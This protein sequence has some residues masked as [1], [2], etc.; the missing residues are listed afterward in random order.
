MARQVLTLNEPDTGGIVD[1]TAQTILPADDA[2]FANDGNV[3]LRVLNNAGTSF[4]I[5]F[6]IPG[7]VDEAAGIVKSDNV[8]SIAAGATHFFHGFDSTTYNQEDDPDALGLEN[9]VYIDVPTSSDFR[10]TAFQV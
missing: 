9:A 7:F 1:P 8:V 2:Y 6:V 3:T 10:I 5:T 4:D